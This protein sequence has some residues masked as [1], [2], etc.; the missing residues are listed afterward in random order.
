[1][2][3]ASIHDKKLCDLIFGSECYLSYILAPP[4]DFY[5]QV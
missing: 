2:Y 5:M 4:S 3:T 1:M